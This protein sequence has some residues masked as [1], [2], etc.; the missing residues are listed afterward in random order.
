M[1]S[2][3]EWQIIDAM[4]TFDTTSPANEVEVGTFGELYI[5]APDGLKYD[6]EVVK[7]GLKRVLF[8]VGDGRRFE[9]ERKNGLLERNV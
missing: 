9:W 3:R 2:Y 7:I 5:T 8:P 6:T 4:N 1:D